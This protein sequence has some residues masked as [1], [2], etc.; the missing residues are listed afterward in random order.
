MNIV[1]PPKERGNIWSN[2]KN[3]WRNQQDIGNIHN[4]REIL[5]LFFSVIIQEYIQTLENIGLVNSKVFI[6]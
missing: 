3:L 4:G 6:N 2:W 5:L 1:R